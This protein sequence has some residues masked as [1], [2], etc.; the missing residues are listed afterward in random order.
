MDCHAPLPFLHTGVKF[1]LVTHDRLGCFNK[2]LG[3]NRV[4]LFACLCLDMIDESAV[5]PGKGLGG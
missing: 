5:I 1:R 2:C 3:G 4:N